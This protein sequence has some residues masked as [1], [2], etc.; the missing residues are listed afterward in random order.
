MRVGFTLRVL[1]FLGFL[2]SSQTSLSLVRGTFLVSVHPSDCPNH[3]TP[4]LGP[5][6]YSYLARLDMHGSPRISTTPAACNAEPRLMC[7]LRSL[8]KTSSRLETKPYPARLMENIS[9]PRRYNRRA[10]RAPPV[11]STAENRVMPMQ[12]THDV[13]HHRDRRLIWTRWSGKFERCRTRGR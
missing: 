3:E 9:P 12:L 1:L 8:T 13:V 2:M 10:G 5:T 6:D 7:S 4:R 11:R